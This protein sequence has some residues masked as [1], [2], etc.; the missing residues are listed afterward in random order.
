MSLS[1]TKNPISRLISPVKSFVFVVLNMTIHIVYIG[2]FYYPSCEK[3]TTFKW[4]WWRNE[5]ERLNNSNSFRVTFSFPSEKKNHCR[6]LKGETHFFTRKSRLRSNCWFINS[7][8]N[9]ES[10]KT[11]IFFS[12]LFPEFVTVNWPYHISEIRYI[13]G[14]LCGCSLVRRFS[15]VFLS[16]N[17]NLFFTISHAQCYTN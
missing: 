7:R 15:F 1:L 17:L 3:F 6:F 11:I 10:R 4:R 9:E 16:L 2:Y 12:F 13:S 14:I 5:W 8:D